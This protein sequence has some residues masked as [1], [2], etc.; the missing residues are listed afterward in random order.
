MPPRPKDHKSQ[1]VATEIAN[2]QEG[3]LGLESRATMKGRVK[4]RV[5]VAGNTT[6]P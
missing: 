1:R 5:R 3:R 6:D 2:P 4:V